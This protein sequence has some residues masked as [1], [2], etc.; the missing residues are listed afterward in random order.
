MHIRGRNIVWA[1]IL[2]RWETKPTISRYLK[3]LVLPLTSDEDFI[4]IIVQE[5]S[6]VKADNEKIIPEDAF[7]QEQLWK[8]PGEA[9]WIPED[10]SDLQLRLF[11][12]T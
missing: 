9:E 3:I 12:H 4:W 10:A 8:I 1:D 2:S 11:L 5:I 7:T 6:E